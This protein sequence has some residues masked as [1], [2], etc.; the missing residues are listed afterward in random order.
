M[1]QD[2]HISPQFFLRSSSAYQS[3]KIYLEYDASLAHY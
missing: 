3:L 1:S 2:V